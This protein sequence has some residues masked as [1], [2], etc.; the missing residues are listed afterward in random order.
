[1]KK[2]KNK[3]TKIAILLTKFKRWIKNS[4]SNKLKEN[5]KKNKINSNKFKTIEFKIN[6]S[7]E[8]YH[9]TK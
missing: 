9:L 6:N 8:I 1:M 3:S 2:N 5:K 4:K 7:L